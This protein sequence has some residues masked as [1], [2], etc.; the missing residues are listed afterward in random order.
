MSLKE[1]HRQSTQST[2][3]YSWQH[4]WL[5]IWSSQERFWIVIRLISTLEPKFQRVYE[6][7]ARFEGVDLV[8]QIL[9]CEPSGCHRS[10]HT[11]KRRTFGF[12]LCL[13]LIIFTK[14]RLLFFPPPP[15]TCCCPLGSLW[16]GAPFASSFSISLL[17]F[18][19]SFLGPEVCIQ[20]WESYGGRE[21]ERE[22][23]SKIWKFT[24][25]PNRV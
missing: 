11:L 24:L 10:L 3:S 19:A 9:L 4:N 1:R 2:C 16:L 20:R 8:A 23:E 12:L 15:S 5:F 14:P 6:Q 18:L 21:N 7:P 22:S 13:A 25:G 17:L